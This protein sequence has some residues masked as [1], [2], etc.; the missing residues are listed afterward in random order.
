MIATMLALI[1]LQEAPTETAKRVDALCAQLSDDDMETR[2]KATAEL[3]AIG[4]PALK[5]V[6]VLRERGDAEVRGRAG[7][8]Y[9]KIV[10]SLRGKALKL[11]LTLLDREIRA[12]HEIRFEAKLKNVE[13]F[14]IEVALS[15]G[16]VLNPWT[17]SYYNPQQQEAQQ[18]RQLKQVQ[19][20]N[21]DW[22]GAPAM[23]RKV[24]IQPGEC[25]DVTRETA[26]ALVAVEGKHKVT[27][28][29]MAATELGDDGELQWNNAWGNARNNR[30]NR[31]NRANLVRVQQRAGQQAAP[32]QTMNATEEAT[33]GPKPV[34]AEAEIRMIKE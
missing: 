33:D 1:L 7:E 32:Q 21:N 26:V 9:E 6:A 19:W 11:E 22:N 15:A 16:W 14:P 18:V 13:E 5:S 27:A 8:A 31:V 30:V 2:E 4:R 20:S 34:T 25:V 23:V 10:E 24:T 12:G 28:T 3:A 29:W 17:N